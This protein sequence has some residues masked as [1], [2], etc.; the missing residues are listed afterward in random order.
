MFQVKSRK[1]TLRKHT[2]NLTLATSTRW[3]K[4]RNGHRCKKRQRVLHLKQTDFIAILHTDFPFHH[5]FLNFLQLILSLYIR[6]VWQLVPIALGLWGY[7]R[8]VCVF[9]LFWVCR[10]F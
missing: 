1:M 8:F 2:L 4:L 5:N 10:S 7:V 9:M 6:T 3:H